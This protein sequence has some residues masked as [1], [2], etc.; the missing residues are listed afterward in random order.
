[1]TAAQCHGRTG[2]FCGPNTC[3]PGRTGTEN[4]NPMIIP[5]WPMPDRHGLSRKPTAD[6]YLPVNFPASDGVALS[7]PLAMGHGRTSKGALR[8]G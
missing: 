4:R 3:T 1:M 8:R 6:L 2:L 7:P 5:F